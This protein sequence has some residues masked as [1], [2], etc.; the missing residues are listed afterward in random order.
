MKPTPGPW[1]AT[2]NDHGWTVAG[3]SPRP[4]DD[5][6]W[7]VAKTESDEPEDEHNARLLAAAP[8]L[9]YALQ[10]CL[11]QLVAYEEKRWLGDAWRTRVGLW[12]DI[13]RA[14]A[15]IAKAEGTEP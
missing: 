11:E 13:A 3:P 15:A 7:L 12:D 8:E 5:K 2:R 1:T 10:E 6:L 14:R 9:L 4:N